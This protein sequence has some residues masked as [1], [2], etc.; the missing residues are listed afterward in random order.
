MFE[1]GLR[2]IW[3]IMEI[4]EGVIRDR[5]A[6]IRGWALIRINTVSDPRFKES[7]FN[8]T[9]CNDTFLCNL[10]MS[11]S[12]PSSFLNLIASAQR[13]SFHIQ[14]NSRLSD[15]IV[16]PGYQ[17]FSRVQR[18][19]SVLFARVTIKTWQKPETALEKSLAPRVVI[20]VL[21]SLSFLKEN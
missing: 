18:E 20:I 11:C 13:I 16:Y 10:F 17:S 12:F 19:F 4:E 2:I 3:R 7:C 1:F 8:L 14:R 6:L 21:P 9:V 15:V 5:W